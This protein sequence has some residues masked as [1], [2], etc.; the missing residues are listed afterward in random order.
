MRN[1]HK[2]KRRRQMYC[3]IRKNAVDAL[4]GEH[5]NA[6]W[7]QMAHMI[8]DEVWFKAVVNIQKRAGWPNLNI[9][10]WDAFKTGYGIKQSLAIRRLTD[11]KDGT[12]SLMAIVNKLISNKP[13]LTREVMVGYDETPMDV[14]P[15]FQAMANSV[16]YENG[17]QS[18]GE[19]QY[20]EGVRVGTADP[21]ATQWWSDADLAH[22]A[23]DRLRNAPL[24]EPRL[25]TDP[26]SGEVLDRLKTALTSDAIGR[27]RYQCDKYLAHADLSDLSK[28]PASPTFND[29]HDSVAT[30]VAVKQFLLG[31]FF[32]HS[33][34]SVVPTFQGHRFENLSVPLVPPM[35]VANYREVWDEVEEEVEAW[36]DVDQSR[37]FG[38]HS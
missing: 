24:S 18:D 22:A 15:L 35:P 12:A 32:N 13:L 8:I 27:V 1:E 9:H 31:D 10:L 26:I 33:G 38:I 16:K 37:R 7:N 5:P 19:D 23:F 34:G 36:G 2:L 29:I 3:L 25:P 4:G 6:V 14:G 11:P 28:G 21:V 17:D 20:P 30:L